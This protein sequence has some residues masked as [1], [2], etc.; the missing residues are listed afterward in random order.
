VSDEGIEFEVILEQFNQATYMRGR[1]TGFQRSEV[2]TEYIFSAG[3]RRNQTT[4]RD[5]LQL[6]FSSGNIA[7]GSVMLEGVRG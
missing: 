2:P 3:G 5:A 7:S 1:A 4:A 6:L